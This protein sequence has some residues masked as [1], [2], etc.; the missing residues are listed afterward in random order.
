MKKFVQHIFS[1]RKDRNAR[2]HFCGGVFVFKN[3]HINHLLFACEKCKPSNKNKV[4]GTKK[5]YIFADNDFVF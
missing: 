4:A 3:S 2:C 5:V 1:L